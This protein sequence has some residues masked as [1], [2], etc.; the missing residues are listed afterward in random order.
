MGYLTLKRRHSCCFSMHHWENDKGSSNLE[1]GVAAVLG[2]FTI[3]VFKEII[4]RAEAEYYSPDAIRR[5]LSRL[6]YMWDNR[7][8]T[9]EE[10]LS[11]EQSLFERLKEGQER[12]IE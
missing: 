6:Q 11:R 8:I 1:L 5:E 9:R 2:K 12:G 3:W 10:Y 4:A 7:E